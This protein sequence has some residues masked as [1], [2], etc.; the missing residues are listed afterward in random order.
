MK[1]KFFGVEK[2]NYQDYQNKW[3]FIRKNDIILK[4]YCRD[5]IEYK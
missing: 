5:K 2:N 3:T 4:K 1:V